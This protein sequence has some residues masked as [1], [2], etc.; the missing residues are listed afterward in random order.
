MGMERELV[1]ECNAHGHVEEICWRYKL[2]GEKSQM[3]YGC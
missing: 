1:P 2:G 3:F